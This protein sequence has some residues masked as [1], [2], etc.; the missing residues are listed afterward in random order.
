MDLIAEA[1]GDPGFDGLLPHHVAV[2]VTKLDEP[3]VYRTAESLRLLTQDP[4]HP[5]GFPTVHHTDA[6]TLLLNLC[7]VGRN[8]ASAVLPQLLETYFHPERIA[9]FATSSVGFM[10]D[11]RT[12]VFSP[13]DTENIYR[14]AS[15][16]TVV[17]GPVNPVN[18][19]EPV[20]WLVQQMAQAA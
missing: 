7:K 14:I 15:G 3:R 20:L 8:G 9:Y 1:S 18:V 6:R 12:R 10:V 19:V 5:Y 17:R 13:H 4:H 16:S 2:C 11:K